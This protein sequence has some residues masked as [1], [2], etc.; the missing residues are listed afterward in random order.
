MKM[1]MAREII[2]TSREALEAEAVARA[3]GAEAGT[4]P[5][6]LT[7]AGRAED[8]IQDLVAD[9]KMA[10]GLSGK[11]AIVMIVAIV[12]T[13]AIVAIVMTAAVIVTVVT[14]VVVTEA[15]VMIVGQGGIALALVEDH[16]DQKIRRSILIFNEEVR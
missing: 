2:Q 5:T 13:V 14:T 10:E 4:G 8:L 15:I 12:M 1:G 11:G 9:P 7:M 6:G 3:A 16:T